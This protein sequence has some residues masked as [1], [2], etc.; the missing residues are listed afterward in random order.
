MKIVGYLYLQE[1][2]SVLLIEL[3]IINLFL[4]LVVKRKNV[5]NTI[6]FY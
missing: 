5:G 1:V 2:T 3:G 6:N 4:N